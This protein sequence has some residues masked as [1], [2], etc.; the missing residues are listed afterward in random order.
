MGKSIYEEAIE[1]LDSKETFMEIN[2]STLWI[3]EYSD[4]MSL[5][6]VIKKA[7][8]QEKL[9]ELQKNIIK[10]YEILGRTCEYDPA[11]EVVRDECYKALRHWKKELKDLEINEN[12]K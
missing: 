4:Y 7:Q 6:G 10:Q 11:D 5:V 12:S 9:L 8:Q 1:L 3:L 2:L